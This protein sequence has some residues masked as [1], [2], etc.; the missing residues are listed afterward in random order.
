M[1]GMD[2]EVRIVSVVSGSSRMRVLYGFA[3]VETRTQSESMVPGRPCAR[4]RLETCRLGRWLLC[5]REKR[6]MKE[7]MIN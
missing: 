2:T 3:E 1:P 4:Q 6:D 7:S 5:R